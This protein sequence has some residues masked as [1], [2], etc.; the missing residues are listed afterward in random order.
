MLDK[1]LGSGTTYHGLNP[2]LSTSSAVTM[3]RLLILL[4]PQYLHL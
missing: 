2:I 4:E 3:G 1:S